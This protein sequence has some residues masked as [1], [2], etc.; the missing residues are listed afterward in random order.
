MNQF[1]NVLSHKQVAR[2]IIIRAYAHQL[3]RLMPTNIPTGGVNSGFS[4]G[5]GG[6]HPK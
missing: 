6:E 3:S 5:L 4:I 2:P 1:L